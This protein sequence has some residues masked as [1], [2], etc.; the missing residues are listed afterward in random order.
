M[1]RWRL[2]GLESHHPYELSSRPENGGLA[3]ATLTA[4]PAAGR[5]LVLDEPTAGLDAVGA[6]AVETQI[7]NLT[8][9][10]T[11]HRGHHP[12]DGSCAGGLPPGRGGWGE[13]QVLGEGRPIDMM[14]D[15]DLMARAGLE[16]PALLPLI[17]WLERAPAC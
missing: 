16:P 7:A 12:S 9:I 14:R 4:L 8:E 3:L 1:R 6:A 13:G 5:S 2:D 11:R 10:G 17:D 15:R